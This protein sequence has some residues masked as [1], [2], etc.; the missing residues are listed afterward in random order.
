MI[1]GLR[2]TP[3]TQRQKLQVQ[4]ERRPLNLDH[5]NDIKLAW[6]PKHTVVI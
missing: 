5:I 2:I 3:Q 1:D 6:Y 4:H